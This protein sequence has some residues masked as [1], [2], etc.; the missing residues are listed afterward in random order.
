MHSTEHAEELRNSLTG[1]EGGAISHTIMSKSCITSNDMGHWDL[2]DGTSNLF[3]NPASASLVN[4]IYSKFLQQN[5]KEAWSDLRTTRISTEE[6]M[7]E[8]LFEL[9][10]IMERPDMRTKHSLSPISFSC[11]SE[12][13]AQRQEKIMKE[14]EER[15]DTFS[16]LD[17]DGRPLRKYDGWLVQ[18]RDSDCFVLRRFSDRGGQHWFRG[19]IGRISIASGS[20][21]CALVHSWPFPQDVSS[22]GAKAVP[23]ND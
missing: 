12:E 2:T 23:E 3:L 6:R 15:G 16:P 5:V 9:A 4:K 10:D 19:D 20:S 14:Y 13:S 18:M 7:Q 8:A 11:L 1:V 22:I 17:S 21:G